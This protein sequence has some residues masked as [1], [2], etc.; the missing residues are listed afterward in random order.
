MA[1]PC[2]SLRRTLLTHPQSLNANVASLRAVNGKIEGSFTSST[3]LDLTTDNAP[4]R[5][6][7]NLINKDERD[8]TVLRMNSRNGYVSISNKLFLH[9]LM[10]MHHV[11]TSRRTWT[12]RRP[13]ITST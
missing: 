2:D 9:N 4:I 10:A 1:C 3:T 8:G 5:V 7:V 6:H 12:S 13:A 11:A